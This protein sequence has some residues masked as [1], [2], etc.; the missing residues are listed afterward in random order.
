MPLAVRVEIMGAT[1][2]HRE[3]LS[4][5]ERWKNELRAV[6]SDISGGTMWLEKIRFATRE[7]AE[8]G[9]GPQSEA[10]VELISAVD[11]LTANADLVRAAVEALAD[12]NEKLPHE[13]KSG[14]E[15][16]RLDD[17]ETVKRAAEAVKQLLM[18]RIMAGGVEL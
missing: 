4:N 3:L 1:G 14:D 2:A 5:P 12:L 13:L 8:A 18:E 6:A 17:P 9:T 15:A 7:A 10:L 11:G 16:I